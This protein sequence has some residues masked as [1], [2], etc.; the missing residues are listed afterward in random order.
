LEAERKKTE[1][2]RPV[3][4]EQGATLV[5]RAV[6]GR[7]IISSPT[8][9]PPQATA[10]NP[11]LLSDADVQLFRQ[12]QEKP[13]AHPVTVKGVSG[14]QFGVWA[15]NA[16]RVSVVGDFN[17]WEGVEAGPVK[18]HHQSHSL[19]LT[20]PPLSASFFL[21]QGGNSKR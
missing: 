11:H 21:S 15:P 17:Q 7:T 19:R 2:G 6:E 5:R 9:E 12:L 20:L 4:P 1:A 10:V 16:E 8:P 14:V 18:W 3:K 13:G